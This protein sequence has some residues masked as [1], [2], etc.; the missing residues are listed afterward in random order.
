M[1]PLGIAGQ[2]N[3]VPY[4]VVEALGENLELRF[5]RRE[6]E[7]RMSAA[8]QKIQERK[9]WRLGLGEKGCE[10]VCLLCAGITGQSKVCGL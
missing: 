6:D 9:L 5:T 3:G 2:G 4:R 8:H 7:Q 10:R 1:L